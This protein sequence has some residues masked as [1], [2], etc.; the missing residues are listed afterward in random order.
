MW[1]DHRP[2]TQVTVPCKHLGP[3][4]IEDQY[5]QEDMNAFQSCKVNS[6]FPGFIF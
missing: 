3:D 4:Y 6:V 1:S 5:K 2:L